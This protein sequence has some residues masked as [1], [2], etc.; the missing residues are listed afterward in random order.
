MYGSDRRVRSQP[1][2]YYHLGQAQGFCLGRID[3]AVCAQQ[4]LGTIRRIALYEIEPNRI[5]RIATGDLVLSG[6]DARLLEWPFRFSLG[7]QLLLKGRQ[8]TVQSFGF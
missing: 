7:G 2:R 8:A 4:V 6:G 5:V 3:L 1:P